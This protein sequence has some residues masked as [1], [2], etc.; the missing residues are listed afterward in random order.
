MPA[1]FRG[2]KVESIEGID[3]NRQI[4]EK[5]SDESQINPRIDRR[6]IQSSRIKIST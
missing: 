1:C 5:V 2:K 4:R 3:L 6:M